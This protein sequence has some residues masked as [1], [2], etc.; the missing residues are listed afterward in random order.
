MIDAKEHAKLLLE[1]C[2]RPL[3]AP[4]DIMAVDPDYTAAVIQAAMEIAFSAGAAGFKLA[5]PDALRVAV[6]GRAQRLFAAD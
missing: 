1:E 4:N 3:H 5:A 2:R 6:N